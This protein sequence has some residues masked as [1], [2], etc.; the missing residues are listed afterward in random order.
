MKDTKRRIYFLFSN[1]QVRFWHYICMLQEMM[2]S[3]SASIC[4]VY[5]MVPAKILLLVKIG[6][7]TVGS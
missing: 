7:G 1:L 4:L 2:S 3:S 5:V 6:K